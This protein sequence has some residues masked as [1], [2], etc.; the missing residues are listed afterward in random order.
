VDRVDWVVSLL[1]LSFG[2]GVVQAMR[3]RQLSER[4]GLP[5]LG[6]SLLLVGSIFVRKP[7]DRLAA[8]LGVQ[9]APALWLLVSMV[10]LLGICLRLTMVVTN[11]QARV[12][13]LTQEL[14]LL[15]RTERK[16]KSS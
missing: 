1:G 4:D 9:Y 14:A 8:W 3:R 13:R 12:V 16:G 2:W 7:L 5:W 10:G 15:E 6:L 11:L